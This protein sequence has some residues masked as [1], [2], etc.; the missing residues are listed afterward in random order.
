M[1]RVV[2][3]ANNEFDIRG[4]IDLQTVTR[5]TVCDEVKTLK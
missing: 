2:L 3:V 4:E 5:Q 1:R